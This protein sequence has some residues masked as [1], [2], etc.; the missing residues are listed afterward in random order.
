MPTVDATAQLL[1]FL[2]YVFLGIMLPTVY[3]ILHS[4]L[5][6]IRRKHLLSVIF[7]VIF[8]VF[9]LYI[10]WVVNFRLNDGQ[11]RIY[12]A[13]GLAIGALAY[14]T[15]L[16]SFLDNFGKTL[17]TLFNKGKRAAKREKILRK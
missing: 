16:F 10:M 3:H 11:F 9:A 15:I 13:L 5:R 2:V 12:I 4:L 8:G 17:Y 14:A 1:L 6:P 7:D